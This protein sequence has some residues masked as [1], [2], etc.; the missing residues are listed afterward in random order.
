MKKLMLRLVVGMF[1]IMLPFTVQAYT[2]SDPVGDAIGEQT[3]E[4]YGINMYN[5]TP[6]VYSGRITFDLFTNYPKDGLNVSGWDTKPADLFIYETYDKNWWNDNR[7]ISQEYLWAIP[8]VSHDGFNAGT[9]Y[10]VKDYYVSD[11]FDPSSGSLPYN[12]NIPVRIATIGN[13]YGYTA[14]G[15]LS[16]EWN[17]LSGGFP[18]YRISIVTAG[19]QDDPNGTY[20]LLWGTATCANDVITG[21]TAIPEPTTLLLLGLGLI[22]IAGIRR[23]LRM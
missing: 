15:D 7:G 22:A 12:H 14:F 1:F 23:K 9:M 13:N 21:R 8:L 16:I 3:F 4:S 5:Y 19:Y 2:I 17:T 20:S 18:D 11:D 6:G 10:A